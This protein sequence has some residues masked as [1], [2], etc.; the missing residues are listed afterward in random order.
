[1]DLFGRKNQRRRRKRKIPLSQMVDKII[2]SLLIWLVIII[3]FLL[4]IYIYLR[5]SM[6]QKGFVMLQLKEMR[7]Q[8]DLKNKLD[9]SLLIELK[10]LNTMEDNEVVDAMSPA[11]EQNFIGN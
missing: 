2:R 9:K 3:V 10:R 4:L 1:M 7:Q 6:A 11:T 5:S 8:L